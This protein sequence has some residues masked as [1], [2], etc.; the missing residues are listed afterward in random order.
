MSRPANLQRIEE[1]QTAILRENKIPE[2]F[3]AY[4]IRHAVIS[5]L[6]RQQDADLKAINAY[7]RWA[8]GS[9]VA[10]E[11]YTVLLVQDTNW[12]LKTIGKSVLQRGEDYQTD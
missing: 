7:A 9:R 2:T 3:T 8:P 1:E 4:S 11:Y 10:Q 5:H 6:E 12:I